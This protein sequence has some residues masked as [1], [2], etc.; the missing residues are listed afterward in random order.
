V[1]IMEDCMSDWTTETFAN[2][3]KDIQKQ[4]Q[5][6]E[7]AQLRHLKELEQEKMEESEDE[8]ITYINMDGLNQVHSKK[9]SRQPSSIN[10]A[11]SNK[12]KRKVPMAS[13]TT[14]SKASVSS[15]RRVVTSVTAKSNNTNQMDR[16][17]VIA[18]KALKKAQGTK[19]SSTKKVV[20]IKS[21]P[22][23]SPSRPDL[24]VESTDGKSPSTPKLRSTRRAS[25]GKQPKRFQ[26]TP[27]PV[28]KPRS[29]SSAQHAR[30]QSAKISAQHAHKQSAKIASG[31][32]R[33]V[34]RPP[35]TG[36]IRRT[37][38]GNPPGRPP[39]TGS[40]RRTPTGNPPGRPPGTGSIRRTPTGNPP[41]RPPNKTK[42]IIASGGAG[43]TKAKVASDH[44]SGSGTRVTRA[45]GTSY[46]EPA[47]PIITTNNGNGASY[48]E[49]EED[50]KFGI[51]RWDLLP[52]PLPPLVPI[53]PP[54]I[55]EV[56]TERPE[57]PVRGI[58]I[59]PPE[60]SESEEPPEVSESEEP[61]EVSENEEESSEIECVEDDV[62]S[63]ASSVSP[64]KVIQRKENRTSYSLRQTV[65][66]AKKFSPSSKRYRS[67]GQK[68]TPV[69][70]APIRDQGSNSRQ[71]N[72]SNGSGTSTTSK[73]T[74]KNKTLAPLVA[75]S[76]ATKG[77][78]ATVRRL[79][80]PN[81]S[82]APVIK[83]EDGG[84]GGG[85]PSGETVHENGVA[86][87]LVGARCLRS[88]KVYP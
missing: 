68:K 84:C 82:N 31:A 33:P 25:A 21:P 14:S 83:V 74:G 20:I 30:N 9:T 43:C 18:N 80:F 63:S 13:T 28:K 69:S 5:E 77:G 70:V 72:I 58:K 73:S 61:P 22:P 56:K 44:S 17:K 48:S 41:G 12:S 16:V 4:K 42:A 55:L 79:S 87:K 50:K 76:G 26:E 11:T 6:W 15:H 65:Q 51:E 59:E 54:I 34:G 23:R 60:V 78:K 57:T 75:A 62:A 39:G 71:R 37:P 38:T 53:L 88:R 86:E 40:I 66:A 35:G 52:S 27:S 46:N 7:E 29:M 81:N 24:N 64:V 32:R 45:R 2:A 36:S 85:G 47:P 10:L 67:G 1:K 19:P 3:Q 49:M 8:E